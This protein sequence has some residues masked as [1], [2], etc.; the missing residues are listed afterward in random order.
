MTEANDVI[1]VLFVYKNSRMPALN[2]RFAKPFD[3]VV[4]F[5]CR[6]LGSRDHAIPDLNCLKSQ[7]IVEDLAIEQW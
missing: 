4:E 7:G 1:E 5:Y 3:R 2:E 6:D